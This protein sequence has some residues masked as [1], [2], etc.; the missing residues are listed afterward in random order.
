M[1]KTA[2]VKPAPGLRVPI[3]GTPPKVLPESGAEVPLDEYWRNRLRDGDVIEVTPAAAATASKK[4][5]S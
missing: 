5:E 2:T 1:A 4:K 3:P